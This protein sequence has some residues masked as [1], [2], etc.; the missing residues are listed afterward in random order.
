MSFG[1]RCGQTA[2]PLTKGHE[3][4]RPS[5][6]GAVKTGEAAREA[7][8]LDGEHGDGGGTAALFSLPFISSAAVPA[9][10]RRMKRT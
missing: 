7:G 10:R 9:R 5:T 3:G 2:A 1:E 8:C 6:R 4:E